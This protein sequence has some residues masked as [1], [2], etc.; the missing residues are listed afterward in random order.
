MI[1]EQL[2]TMMTET[3]YPISCIATARK[4]DCIVYQYIPLLSDGVNGL[5]SIK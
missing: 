4:C 2:K 3:G 5:M 1:A